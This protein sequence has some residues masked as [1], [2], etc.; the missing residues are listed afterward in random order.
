M[1]LPSS[2]AQRQL[3]ID[4]NRRHRGSDKGNAPFL[5]EVEGAPGDVVGDR[6]THPAGVSTFRLAG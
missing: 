1:R 3:S 5:L 4:K 6:H 2:G